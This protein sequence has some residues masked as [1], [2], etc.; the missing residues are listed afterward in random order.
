M[1]LVY[2]KDVGTTARRPMTPSRALKAWENTGGVCVI[3]NLKIDGTKDD[4][5]VE[6][7]RALG[8][9]G[10]DND[11]NTGPAHYAC[12]P[13]KD[14]DDLRLM[15]EAK[16][17]KCALLGISES[18]YAGRLKGKS[19]AKAPKQRSA[20]RKPAKT[21]PDRVNPLIAPRSP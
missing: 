11:R 21:P 8:L 19:F 6:H 12:K 18:P 17:E 5:F 2:P 16:R 1:A 3:C 4:W 7:L 13:I 15:S 20:S 10:A 14:A 9:A